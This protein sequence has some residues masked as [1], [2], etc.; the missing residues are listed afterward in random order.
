MQ[1]RTQCIGCCVYHKA[2]GW[3]TFTTAIPFNTVV[4]NVGGC[5]N[6]STGFFTCPVRGFYQ[7]NGSSYGSGKT[8]SQQ[9][10]TILKNNSMFAM[11]DSTNIGFSISA[12]VFC[13]AGDTLALGCYASNWPVTI[14]ATQGHNNFSVVLVSRA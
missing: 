13:E 7:V 14:Y 6:P 1:E 4:Y 9:R 11:I 2:G 8:T 3:A 12:V 10:P 5:Y